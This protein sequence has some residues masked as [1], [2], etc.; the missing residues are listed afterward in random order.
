MSRFYKTTYTCNFDMAWYPFDTQRCSMVYVLETVLEKDVELVLGNLK[1]SGPLELTQYFI[2]ERRMYRKKVDKRNMIFVDVFLGRKLLSIIMTV[3]VP[4][5]ILNFVGHASNFFKEF[6]FE[7]IISVNVTTML[8]ITT[9]F[10]NVSNNLPK[11]AYIKMI[12]IWLLFNLTKP[13]VDILVT[14]YIDSLKSDESREINHHGE[15]RLV[16]EEEEDEMPGKRILVAPAQVDPTDLVHTN[17]QLQ[18]RAL[19]NHYDNLKKRENA[20]REAKIRRWKRFSIVT[21]PVI[22]IAFVIG[23]WT[24]GLT[25]YFRVL[26]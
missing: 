22:C 26:D 9:M 13:F 12:D 15:T 19:K 3:F 8:V 17:E 7:A 10:I 18:Q 14:T 16:G 20:K 5:L 4:S 24:L 23:Y 6:F 25:E 1:Y 11:T 2:K 21:N